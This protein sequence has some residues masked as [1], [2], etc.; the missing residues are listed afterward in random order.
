MVANKP[1][2]NT[3]SLTTSYSTIM[4]Y[5]QLSMASGTSSQVNQIAVIFK[6]L[7]GDIT[8]NSNFYQNASLVN[9]TTITMKALLIS[10]SLFPI[11][12]SSLET[13]YNMSR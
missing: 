11:N 10:T 8:S 12:N 4:K 9:Y 6:S 3:T 7:V 1:T 2:M 5:I 13:H